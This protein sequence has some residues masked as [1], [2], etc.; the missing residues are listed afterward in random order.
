MDMDNF[1][2]TIVFD[3]AFIQDKSNHWSIGGNSVINRI[4]LLDLLNQFD[5]IHMLKKYLYHTRLPRTIS[6]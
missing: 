2:I 4:D 3:G 5:K 1:S 6:I